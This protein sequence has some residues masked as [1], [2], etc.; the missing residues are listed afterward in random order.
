MELV[1]IELIRSDKGKLEFDST[2]KFKET[3]KFTIVITEAIIDNIF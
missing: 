3:K 2:D 1:E